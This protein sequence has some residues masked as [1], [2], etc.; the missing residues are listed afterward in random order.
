MGTIRSIYE[1]V[2]TAR[3]Y[4]P[5]E[6]DSIVIR[7]ATEIL[8]LNRE[9]QLFEGMLNDGKSLPNY[10][11]ATEEITQGMSGKG[12]PKRSGSPFNMYA[13]GSLFK[14]VE[15]LYNQSQLIF[16]TT[17][18]NHPFIKQ[19]PQLAEKLFGLTKENQHKLNYE[20]LL[21]ELRKWVQSTMK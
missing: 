14:S 15:A 7:L 19:R 1:K 8:D 2:V 5:D 16:K 12:Y 3:R 4:M 10:S 11:R 6:V 17:D 21:P 13:T 20:M 9:D 18:P